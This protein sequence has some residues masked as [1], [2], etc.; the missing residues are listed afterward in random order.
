MGTRHLIRSQLT[1]NH[2]ELDK[3]LSDFRHSSDLTGEN[4]KNH[5]CGVISSA[6]KHSLGLGLTRKGREE[7]GIIALMQAVREEVCGG[8]KEWSEIVRESN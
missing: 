3:D 2:Q 5:P 1:E 8:Q 7:P 4:A 6:V